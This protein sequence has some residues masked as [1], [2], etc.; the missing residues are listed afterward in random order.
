MTIWTFKACDGITPIRSQH[1]FAELQL[2][3]RWDNVS[4]LWMIPFSYEYESNSMLLLLSIDFVFSL[5]RR[6]SEKKN[7]FVSDD[8]LIFTSA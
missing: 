7:F 3:K 4:S 2:K 8:T 5:S 6:I 1:L